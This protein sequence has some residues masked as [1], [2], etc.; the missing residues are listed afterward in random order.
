MATWRSQGPAR[1]VRIPAPPDHLADPAG[2]AGGTSYDTATKIAIGLD[3]GTNQGDTAVAIGLEAAQTN[4]NNDAIAIG[5]RAGKLTQRSYAIAIGYETG[6]TEQLAN[7]VAIGH[8]AGKT[9]Q[10][11]SAVAIGNSAGYDTQSGYAVAIGNGAGYTVQS[12][13]AIAIGVSAGGLYQRPDAIAIGSSAGAS[14]QLASSIAIGNEA[15]KSGQGLASIALGLGTA[16]TTQGQEAIAIGKQAGE[17]NQAVY[18]VA[19]GS[20][21]GTTQQKDFAVAV[22]YRAGS[23]NQ[24]ASAVA[25]GK[26]AGQSSQSTNAVAIGTSAGINGQGENSIAIGHLAGPSAMAA[27]SIVINATGSPVNTPN[28]G[29]FVKPITDRYPGTSAQLHYEVST[30]EIFSKTKLSYSMDDDTILRLLIT[31]NVLPTRIYAAAMDDIISSADRGK[32][33]T[34]VGSRTNYNLRFTYGFVYDGFR[35]IA[36]G[37]PSAGSNTPILY[38]TDFMTWAPCAALAYPI[39]YQQT[40]IDVNWNG[41]SFIALSGE[42]NDDNVVR[43]FTNCNIWRSTN[44]IDW[45]LPNGGNIINTVEPV[46]FNS[47][48]WMNN[49]WVVVGSTPHFQDANGSNIITTSIDDGRSWIQRS[50]PSEAAYLSD[51]LYDGQKWVACGGRGN[52]SALY[53]SYGDTWTWT[54]ST[55]GQNSWPRGYYSS[56]AW[57][58]DPKNPVY[59]AVGYLHDSNSNNLNYT[60]YSRNGIDWSVTRFDTA[61]FSN[62]GSKVRWIV[63]TFVA[64]GQNLDGPS[65][66]LYG[67]SGEYWNISVGE[68]LQN[69]STAPNNQE[70]GTGITV[71]LSRNFQI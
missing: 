24:A 33:W 56:I 46:S 36:H 57:N 2:P 64:V 50:G 48:V 7:A 38:S 40:V 43:K 69:T 35:W 39:F 14:E 59:V 44:G 31:K 19:I 65:A 15:G 60:F 61:R 6:V 27:N 52:D 62:F 58:E 45:V 13:N 47:V 26:E 21:T 25:I 12:T 30:G 41:S 22:G 5:T 70:R 4:Q 11:N 54:K 1:G 17:T 66:P 34:S 42:V 51:I 16:K 23:S 8:I 28:T 18:A 3:A 53:Y 37:V 63:D 32:T 67:A 71:A 29:F 20:E 10:G 9:N 68:T 55:T 49:M